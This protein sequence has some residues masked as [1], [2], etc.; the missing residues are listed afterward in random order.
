MRSLKPP[1]QVEQAHA[2]IVAALIG[3]SLHDAEW[4]L[5]VAQ[6]VLHR[7]TESVLQDAVF[8]SAM[9]KPVALRESGDMYDAVQRASTL[10]GPCDPPE[11]EVATAI[12]RRPSPV[13]SGGVTP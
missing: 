12:P 7:A 11:P 2:Q 13:L 9:V 4:A 8:D 5:D 1:P 10:R 6:G 3:L